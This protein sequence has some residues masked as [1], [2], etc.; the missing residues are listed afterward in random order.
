MAL[1]SVKTPTK[2]VASPYLYRETALTLP[3]GRTARQYPQK[4]PQAGVRFRVFFEVVFGFSSMLLSRFFA[5]LP[6]ALLCVAGTGLAQRHDVGSSP[7][8]AP[9]PKQT[10]V[11][12]AIVPD[13]L[14]SG[15][16]ALQFSVASAPVSAP[17]LLSVQL[18]SS[19]DRIRTAALAAIGAPA[20]YAV[21][22]RVAFPH[23][24]H[25]D[26]L[27]LGNSYAFD[28]L[29]TVELDQH[30][31]TAVLAPEDQ[32][33][34]RLATASY[35]TPFSDPSMTPA[36]FLRANRSTRQP[37]F[38]TATFHT[39]TMGSNGDFADTE[40][41]L[42]I[43]GGRA[44]ITMSF[45]SAERTCDPTHQKPCDFT[46]RWIQP[47]TTDPKD[48]V[49]LVTAAGH[50]RSGDAGE[51]VAHAE[52]YEAAHL[53]TFTCQPF[54]FSDETLRFD[55]VSDA[56]P[57]F[58]SHDLPREGQHDSPHDIPHDQPLH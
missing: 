50:V 17:E 6:V 14:N 11:P 28:A 42:R 31:V 24:V 56:V 30:I 55:A 46:E 26:F 40:V 18:Q 15:L 57:C 48:E 16:G 13:P 12:P 4:P 49:M 51:T 25:L 5:Y 7:P 8:T 38:Y 58:A 37:Q 44:V 52:N 3:A 43:L 10:V 19:N 32:E 54:L 22:G 1:S 45:A 34:H 20:Q 39:H 2:F 27:A 53:R 36:T 21:P 47:G 29:L 23:S 9:P 41:H 35:A 33:W